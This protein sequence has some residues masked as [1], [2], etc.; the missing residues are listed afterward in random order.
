MYLWIPLKITV[1][2]AK[3]IEIFRRP[4]MKSVLMSCFILLTIIFLSACNNSSTE[5][6]ESK[7]MQYSEESEQED[8]HEQDESYEEQE[9][10]HQQDKSY[11]EQEDS[12]Q[13]DKSYE[14]QESEENEILDWPEIGENGVDEELFLKNLDT[15]TLEA[16]A[17]ELQA[18][19]EETTKEEQDNPE[20]VLSEGFTRVFRS[21]RYNRVIEMGDSAMKPLYW[22]IYK[23]PNT[24]MYEY[25]CAMA[26]YELSGY[27]FSNEDGSLSW[28]NSKELLERFDE[29]ILTERK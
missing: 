23:S 28:T 24:G 6:I 12:H 17:A 26:L 22:I 15:D 11:E 8:S 20:I 9:D 1:L 16:V 7:V 19:V 3:Q 29:K 18:L 5:N 13:Q 10:S 21:E 27:D 2:R 14:E 25:I 4:A